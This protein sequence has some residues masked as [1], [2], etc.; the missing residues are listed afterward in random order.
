M[1]E[2]QGDDSAESHLSKRACSGVFPPQGLPQPM[3]ALT[4]L[5]LVL[6]V[7]ESKW[8]CLASPNSEETPPTLGGLLAW[9]SHTHTHKTSDKAQL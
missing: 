4:T 1:I 9:W 8:G 6:W 2:Q 7:L 5:G 3:P